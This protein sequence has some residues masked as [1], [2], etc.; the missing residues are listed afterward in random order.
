MKAQVANQTNADSGKNSSSVEPNFQQ[1]FIKSLQDRI[2]SLERQLNQ[3]QQII[4]KL[5]EDRSLDSR[6]RSP[7]PEQFEKTQSRM[8]SRKAAPSSLF[9][10]PV[11]SAP[12]RSGSQPLEQ[13]IEE[14]VQW[15]SQ[16]IQ[17]S[18]EKS[19]QPVK[20]GKST[21]NRSLTSAAIPIQNRFS[22]LSN[23]T[24]QNQSS[25]NKNNE[26][27]QTVS[28]NKGQE[29]VL[30]AQSATSNK[31]PGKQQTTKGNERNEENTRGTGK[32]ESNK[33]RG[34]TIIGD[35]IVKNLDARQMKRSLKHGKNVYIHSH[36]GATT[37]DMN[38]YA[39]PPMERN[40]EIV[41]LHVG[42]NDISTTKSADVI[43]NDIHSLAMTLPQRYPDQSGNT[44]KVAV[45]LLIPRTDKE[46]WNEKITRVNEK[47][48][49]LCTSSGIPSISHTNIDGKRHLNRSGV[50]LNWTGT[51]V[52][53]GNLIKFLR[54]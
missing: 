14:P 3:K 25:H 6:S 17:Q 21:R 52:L 39:V 27:F 15:G 12:A 53:A 50:H 40:P 49:S 9:Q 33:R 46:E 34:I 1:L 48:S 23:E 42:C 19:F 29:S 43:A 28:K 16:D 8:I 26:D 4:D 24:E 36:S 44:T 18:P 41:I 47:L 11:V 30:N 35:S 22:V 38:S 7:L 37:K 2:T 10:T 5:L 20:N 32:K 45:S 51:S 54:D 31:G 13:K